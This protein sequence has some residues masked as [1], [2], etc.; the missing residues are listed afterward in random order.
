MAFFLTA[1]NLMTLK[2]KLF[3]YIPYVLN[4]DITAL[5]KAGQ[6]SPEKYFF[7]HVAGSRHVFLLLH[8]YVD[9]RM[10]TSRVLMMYG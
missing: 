3:T 10:A 1:I 9:L 6:I 5:L 7:P 4:L 2:L 8:M